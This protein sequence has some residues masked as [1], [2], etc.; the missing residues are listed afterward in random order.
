MDRQDVMTLKELTQYPLPQV[1]WE[2]VESQRALIVQLSS[3]VEIVIQPKPVLQ[4]L[5]VLEGYVPQ[6]WKEAIYDPA[7]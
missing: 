7:A 2:V 6:G 3:G 5:P 1:L 4:A